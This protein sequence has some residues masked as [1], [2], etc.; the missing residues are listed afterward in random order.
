MADSRINAWLSR[1]PLSGPNLA[2]LGLGALIV[3]EL[4]RIATALFGSTQI[5]F[6]PSSAQRAPS[7]HNPHADVA[8]IV[9]AH[10]FGVATGDSDAQ[11]PGNAQP[12]TA[13]LVLAGTIAT[14][15]PRHGMAIIADSGPSKVYS[16]GDS[17][18]GATLHSVYLDHVIL[19]RGGTL[20]TL[21]LP[22]L[23]GAR[24]PSRPTP[25]DA[26]SRVAARTTRQNSG[27]FSEVARVVAFNDSRAGTLRGFHVYPGRNRSAFIGS[28][29][30]GGDLVIAINGVAINGSQ[31]AQEMLDTI[32]T[33][34][35][36]TL[37]IER[38]GH[39]QD[40]TLSDTQ[41][42]AETS[43]NVETAI[44]TPAGAGD[45]PAAP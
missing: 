28:G 24:Q 16:V 21:G 33:S 35:A 23:P 17:L 34:A 45:P 43:S 41:A 12:T 25:A 18:S 44:A 29:L 6:A 9:A 4:A 42:A 22:R 13:N 5:K 19:D 2:S 8:G 14:E 37:T 36:P 10:L 40:I 31:H 15:D 7:R 26:G 39:V 27:G 1:L 32:Q 20:E 11:D 3:V 38:R 30:K